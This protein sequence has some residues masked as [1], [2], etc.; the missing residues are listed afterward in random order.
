MPGVRQRRRGTG[1][2]AQPLALLRIADKMGRERLQRDGPAEPRV[3][4]E[5]HASHAAAAQ[6]PDN[7]VRADDRAR[8]QR[9][10]VCHQL[11]KPF[12]NRLGQKRAG[13]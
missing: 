7:R 9:L 6:L 10:I 1:L 4:R 13:T 3:G 5:I 8:R 12:G 11:G 2:A